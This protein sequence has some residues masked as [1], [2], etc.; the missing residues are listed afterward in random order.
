MGDA[1]CEVS[2]YLD[3]KQNQAISGDE[4]YRQKETISSKLN[5]TETIVQ[6]TEQVSP[7]WYHFETT[8]SSV[9][10]NPLNIVI[11]KSQTM[12]DVF[13]SIQIVAPT[14]V[15]IMIGGETGVGKEIVARAIH[16]A[17]ERNQERFI[18]VNCAAIAEN[19]IESALFG[20]EKGAFT[21]AYNVH[22][23]FSSELV[24]VR[25]SWMK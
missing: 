21:G 2:I 15:N 13:E 7:N 24:R 9:R 14:M 11:G 16:V 19:L 8:E 3:Q 23:G 18:A 1:G 12:R 25:Y 17:S 10:K 22:K 20:H 5:N 4:Y 6:V